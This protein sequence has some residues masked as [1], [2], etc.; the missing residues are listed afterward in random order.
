MVSID[1]RTEFMSDCRIWR[2][3]RKAAKTGHIG[4]I[5]NNSKTQN[6][7]STSKSGANIWYF[8]HYDFDMCFVPQRR[9]LFHHLNF[10]KCSERGV[11][12]ALWLRKACAPPQ[13]TL[14]EHLNSQRWPERGVLCTFW[15]GNVLRAT[16]AC[17]FW[18]SQLPKVLRQWRAFYILTSEFASRRNGVQFSSLI[19]PDGSAPAAL[20]SLLFDLLEPQII[21]KTV[22]HDFST[23]SRTCMFFLLTLSLLFSSLLF[24]DSSHLCFFIC[25][26]CRKFNF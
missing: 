3:I 16:T 6:A 17:T 5:V 9:A 20:A 4:H 19:S 8:V 15:L 25:P 22:N 24:S 12:C 13:R 26:Y 23:F 14:F 2:K 7:A 10:Q 11:F 18:T 1:V 21:G